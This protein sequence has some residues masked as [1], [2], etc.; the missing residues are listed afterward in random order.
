MVRVRHILSCFLSLLFLLS[1]SGC[2]DGDEVL[3][4]VVKEV[5]SRT[6]PGNHTKKRQRLF[7]TYIGV[8]RGDGLTMNIGSHG[9]VIV[10]KK[11]KWGQSTTKAKIQKF[12]HKKH[13]K[14]GALNF[15]TNTYKI[16][17]APRKSGGEWLM[18][19]DG[20]ELTKD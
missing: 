19:I 1:L 14:I 6:F 9:H 12:R 16:D 20:I 5:N 18:T 17:K 3:S 7:K 15:V 11:G 13:I 2:C 4:R 10:E 8:W